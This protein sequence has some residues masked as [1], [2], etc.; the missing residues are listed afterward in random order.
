[1]NLETNLGLAPK[2]PVYWVEIAVPTDEGKKATT[3]LDLGLVDRFD[4]IR[5]EKGNITNVVITYSAVL[6]PLG[7]EYDQAV[8]LHEQYRRYIKNLYGQ[9]VV[10]ESPECENT[11][12]PGGV[13]QRV[14]A[15]P[16][17]NPRLF[18]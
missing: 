16:A 18:N 5:D 17:K 10:P 3:L 9:T 15:D 4:T 2:R 12:R 8:W 11:F 1:M 13:I 14:V 6:K 7:F